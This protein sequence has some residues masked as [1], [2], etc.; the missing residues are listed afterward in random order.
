MTIGTELLLGFTVDTNSAEIARSLSSAGVRVTRRTTV[1]DEAGAINDAVSAALARTGNVLTTGGLGPTRDDITREVVA[2]MFKAPL[3]FQQSIWDELVERFRQVGREP[4]ESN[5][6]QAQVPRG[7]TVLHNRWGSAP[8][9]WLEG[10]KGLVV[11]LPGVPREMRGLMQHE[12]L[13]RLAERTGGAVIRSRTL[14]TIG[15]G[16]SNLA[17]K[18]GD[19]ESVLSPL[20]LAYLPGVTGVDLRITAWSATHSAAE[21]QLERAVRRLRELA[22]DAVF[23]EDMDDLAELVLNEARTRGLRI[24][25]AESCTGGMLGARLTSVPGS[26]AVFS[27]GIIAYDN[28]IKSAE[29]GVPEELIGKHGAVSEEVA[30]AMAVGARQRLGVDIAVSI[31][32]VAGPDG[33][34]NEKP[35]GLVWFG[36]AHDGDV[37]AVRRNIMGDRDAIRER[38]A[39]TALDL[40]RRMLLVLPAL[41]IIG[42]VPKRLRE[43][44]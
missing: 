15:I 11:M 3:E 30:V 12:V 35:V 6:S 44:R 24:G 19:I 26:S 2:G 41:A 42:S 38:A 14:R 36:L 10:E 13:P 25:V 22:G 40:L 27:G 4:V 32:G 1:P 7:A 29:L 5:R 17:E 9:L 23:G 43:S 34:T 33:G 28:R 20:S 39:D 18:L 37:K 21:E 31:T 16:E 8:G